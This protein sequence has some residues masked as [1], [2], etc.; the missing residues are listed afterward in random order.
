MTA[1]GCGCAG[2]R[3]FEDLLAAKMALAD[4]HWKDRASAREKRAYRCPNKSWI[5]HLTSKG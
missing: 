1:S 3:E 4:I 5:Y 2:K